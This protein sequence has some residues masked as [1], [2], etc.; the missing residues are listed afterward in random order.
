MLHTLRD[1]AQIAT[2]NAVLKLDF[3]VAEQRSPRLVSERRL[4][5]WLHH[6]PA[7]QSVHTRTYG[8]RM[9]MPFDSFECMRVCVCVLLTYEL[10]AADKNQAHV[11]IARCAQIRFIIRQRSGQQ[12]FITAKWNSRSMTKRAKKSFVFQFTSTYWKLY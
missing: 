11:V 10:L 6:P 3:Y 8:N 4:A 7:L 9:K 1:D 5:C 12:R 2:K